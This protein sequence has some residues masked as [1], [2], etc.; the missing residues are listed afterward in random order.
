M[1]F[2]NVGMLVLLTPASGAWFSSHDLPLPGHVLIYGPPVSAS[3]FEIWFFHWVMQFLKLNDI[4]CGFYLSTQCFVCFFV[5]QILDIVFS[6]SSHFS[7]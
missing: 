7:Y 4:F 3:S 2:S 6:P 5:F 1:L